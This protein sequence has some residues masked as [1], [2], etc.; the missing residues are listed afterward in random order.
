MPR[1]PG[2]QP[3]GYQP[4]AD[5]S[6]SGPYGGAQIDATFAAASVKLSISDRTPMVSPLA[7]YELLPAKPSPLATWGGSGTLVD[8]QGGKGLVITNK[9]VV[10]KPADITVTWHNG[11]SVAGTFLACDSVADLGAVVIQCP[12]TTKAIPVATA[13]PAVGQ[14]IQ[15]A[16]YPGPERV[17]IRRAGRIMAMNSRS[18]NAINLTLTVVSRHG[19]SGSGIFDPATKTLVGVLWGGD[20]RSSVAVEQADLHRFT[21]HCLGLLGRRPRT[22]TVPPPAPVPPGVPPSHPPGEVPPPVPLPPAGPSSPPA[23]LPAE[24]G[25][26][27]AGLESRLG[28]LLAMEPG[29]R[30]EEIKGHLDKLQTILALAKTGVEEAKNAGL[31]SADRADK[32]AAKVALVDSVLA[33]IE[34]SGGKIDEIILALAPVLKGVASSDGKLGQV[35][36]KLPEIA[37]TVGA[38]GK[39]WGLVDWLVALGAG[40]GGPLGL[41]LSGA[42]IYRK[43]GRAAGATGAVVTDDLVRAIAG[44]LQPQPAQPAQVV[45]TQGPPLPQVVSTVPT[46]VPY[47]SPSEELAAYKRAMAELAQKYPGAVDIL[48]TLKSYAQQMRDPSKRG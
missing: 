34:G 6:G 18:G 44:R 24:L 31:L 23:E 47:E 36:A 25:R 1:V 14:S 5:S 45:V 11:Y 9:H 43:F 30:F 29:K 32:I 46:F 7:G 35:L 41:V 20:G 38:G 28:E 10:N 19:D 48:E 2:F 21:N 17:L 42:A 3:P 27:L 8:V 40:V 33:K 12:D 26:R 16:G 15:Q 13:R 39:A 37:A 4:P 22:P